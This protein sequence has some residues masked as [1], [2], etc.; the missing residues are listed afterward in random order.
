MSTA[1]RNLRR[2]TAK[3]FAE[4]RCAWEIV[5]DLEGRWEVRK[6]QAGAPREHEDVSGLAAHHRF[7]TG[8][9]L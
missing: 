9:I 4:H 1:L 3:I 6:I 8:A 5:G 2:D 7:T